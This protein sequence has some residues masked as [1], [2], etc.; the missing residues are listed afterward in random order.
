MEQEEK[1]IKDRNCRRCMFV[2][3][4]KGKPEGVELCLRYI[5]RKLQEDGGKKNVHTENH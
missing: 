5:E 2:I 1:L 4:C 3:E